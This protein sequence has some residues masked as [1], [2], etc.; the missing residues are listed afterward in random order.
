MSHRCGLS[1]TVHKDLRINPYV[2][3]ALPV[4]RFARKHPPCHSWIAPM[5]HPP[6]PLP[7]FQICVAR[8][9]PRGNLLSRALYPPATLL[10][11]FACSKPLLRSCV[12]LQTC[13]CAEALLPFLPSFHYL[14]LLKMTSTPDSHGN[15]FPFIPIKLDGN[16]RLCEQIYRAQ[17]SGI[18]KHVETVL[19]PFLSNPLHISP[20]HRDPGICTGLISIAFS[21]H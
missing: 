21:R 9:H 15:G 12:A 17:D 18:R 4:I 10:L 11:D 14:I 3:S 5:S 20:K 13:S 2:T 16:E 7:P 6:P 8:V 1:H 19:F